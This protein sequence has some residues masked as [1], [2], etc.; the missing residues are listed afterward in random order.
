MTNFE[1]AAG[2]LGEG[3]D[4]DRPDDAREAALIRKVLRLQ[5][6]HR[7]GGVEPELGGDP[8]PE[9][10]DGDRGGAAADAESH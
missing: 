3:G 6:R 10:S 4:P 9:V 2:G 1:P 5:E 8:E 7:E